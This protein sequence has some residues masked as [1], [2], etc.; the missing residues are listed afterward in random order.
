[1]LWT[2]HPLEIRDLSPQVRGLLAESL[3]WLNAHCDDSGLF[4]APGDASGRIRESVW[5]AAGLLLRDEPGDGARAVAIL[6]RAV[7]AQLI[8]AGQAWHGT[9]RRTEVEPVPGAEAREWIEYDPNW[10]QFLATAFSLILA[11]YGERLPADLG[12]SLR[13]AIELARSSE[14]PDR[15][16]AGYTNIALMKAWLDVEAGDPRGLILARE[17][18]ERF[19]QQG[20]FDEYGSP[21]YYG[22]DLYALALWQ[23]HSSQPE[24][25]G[26]GQRLAGSLWRDIARFYHAGLRNLAGPYSR[27]YGMDLN[28][29][30]STLGLWIWAAM[31][32][33]HA[34]FPR[35]D[36]G[37]E[38]SHDFALAPLVAL[39]AGRMPHVI[40]PDVMHAFVDFDGPRQVSQRIGRRGA[41]LASAWLDE[42]L[43]I[44]AESS[45]VDMHGWEQFHGATIHWRAVAGQGGPAGDIGWLRLRHDG[46]IDA[47]ARPSTLEL[48]LESPTGRSGS[49]SAI[50]IS[51]PGRDLFA[52]ASALS[53]MHWKLPGLEIRLSGTTQ[54]GRIEISGTRAVIE[55]P[56]LPGP[57]RLRLEIP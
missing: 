45:P 20:C 9:F 40:P 38:H 3:A 43:A 55:Y 30:A 1:M 14:P 12:D 44:G 11:E 23:L 15:V 27:A 41:R 6:K 19:D 10:R 34:P 13:T 5:L 18:T 33:A 26:W 53:A 51:L 52:S 56:P 28:G 24:L 48:C 50:E 42:G 35:T 57:R 8:G 22:I 31:G 29:Y 39:L 46:P 17:I 47:R 7:A 25:R 16:G 32:R 21:T 36:A 37:F 2:C 54:D 49:G 4:R